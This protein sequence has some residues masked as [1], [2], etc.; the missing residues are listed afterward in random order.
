VHTEELGSAGIAAAISAGATA[1]TPATRSKGSASTPNEDALLARCEGQQVLLAVA[2][3]HFG[4]RASHQLLRQLGA[5]LATI[6]RSP[7][8]LGE[9]LESL[10]LELSSDRSESTLLVVVHD[11]HKGQGFGYSF[12]DSALAI[13]GP[14]RAEFLSRPR[15]SFVALREEVRPLVDEAESL[16]FFTHPQDLVLVFTDGIHECHYGSAQTSVGTAQ[17]HRCYTACGSDPRSFAE[18]I[19]QQA[20]RGV[21]GNPG[22]QDNIAVLASRSAALAPSA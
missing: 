8:E 6:P 13:V 11:R 10:P 18:K 17:L 12:G 7:G 2:D 14:E 21:N 4:H 22:G 19:A 3:A 5:A 15:A 9:L 1:N 16:L 20:L